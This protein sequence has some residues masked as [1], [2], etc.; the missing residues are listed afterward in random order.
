MK[1]GVI[2]KDILRRY[3]Q[4]RS[5]QMICY[6]GRVGCRLSLVGSSLDSGWIAQDLLDS[7]GLHP[8]PC[9]LDGDLQDPLSSTLPARPWYVP[10][11]LRQVRATEHQ[12]IQ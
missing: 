5:I 12:Q 4:R 1:G 11:H 2:L 6:P 10:V 9:C 7:V 3:T 8:F